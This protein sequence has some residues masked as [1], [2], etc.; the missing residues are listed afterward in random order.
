MNMYLY[1]YMY[2]CMYVCVRL[3]V[4][5]Y[6]KWVSVDRAIQSTV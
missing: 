4:C 6:I 3:C 1:V 2:V 5:V